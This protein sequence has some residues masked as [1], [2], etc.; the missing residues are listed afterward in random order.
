M[1]I[2]NE[3]GLNY[4]VWLC[5]PCYVEKTK[6]ELMYNADLCISPGNVGLMVMDSF[7]FGLPVAT[8]SDFST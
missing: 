7:M 5:G 4:H 3:Y 2:I 6:G 1:I 8:N